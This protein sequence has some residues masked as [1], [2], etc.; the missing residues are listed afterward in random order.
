MLALLTLI[1]AAAPA[2][3]SPLAEY[4]IPGGIVGLVLYV[5]REGRKDREQERKD[6]EVERKAQEDRYA[7]LASDFRAIVQENT[8]SNVALREMI[9]RSLEPRRMGVS[10][11][12]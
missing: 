1:Q 7:A 8:A 9:E 11:G 4:G 3:P 6:R 2:V 10:A 5:W 12:D